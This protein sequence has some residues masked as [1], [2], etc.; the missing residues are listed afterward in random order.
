MKILDVELEYD[1]LDADLLEKYEKENQKLADTIKDPQK[2]EGLS[3]ADSIR[4]QCKIVDEFFD[5][6]FGK[7]TADQLFHGKAHIGHHMEAFG[8]MAE[9]AKNSSQ[10]FA[11]IEEKYSKNRAERRSE[12]K[13]KN[14]TY[15]QHH[16][17]GNK[18]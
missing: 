9:A 3:T 14:K 18:K 10:D 11:R 2:Y 4:V 8:Q 15:H 7:G 16:K 1:F 12:N 6:L 5:A 13:Q 17:H